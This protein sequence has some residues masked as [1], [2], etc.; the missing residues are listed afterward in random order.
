MQQ[1]FRAAVLRTTL[2]LVPIH[3]AP[4]ETT[5]DLNTGY[6]TDNFNW[7]IAANASG[8]ATPNILSDLTWT[9][10][11]IRQIG[12][13]WKHTLADGLQV[14]VAADYGWIRDGR[15]QDS[16]YL[17]NNRTLEFSRS[18]NDTSGDDVWDLAVAAG[19][20]YALEGTGILTP[21][22]GLSHH[23]QNLRL[24]NGNQTIPATG[25]FA[26]LDSTYR[27]HWTGPFIGAELQTDGADV[28]HAFF[29][30]EYHW[31]RFRAA[32]N[33]NLRSDFQHPRSF[34]HEADGVGRILAFGVRSRPLLGGLVVRVTLLFQDWDTDPGI[35]RVFFSDGTVAVTRLNE[36]EWLSRTILLGF[37][38]RL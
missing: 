15:N 11:R 13:N 30:V 10:L 21:F 26:G 34:E 6:R 17:G 22:I 5:L 32:A 33:W 29:R 38:L 1:R 14:R 20:R 2:C 19:R 24:T 4:A 3:A 23:A 25:P 16:D 9:D 28:A 37:E 18:N 8:T 27:A 31:A 12:A 35:D 36:A 7:N